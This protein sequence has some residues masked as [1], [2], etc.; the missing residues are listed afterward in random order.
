[1]PYPDERISIKEYHCVMDISGTNLPTVKIMHNTLGDIVWTRIGTGECM[2]TL[3][4][5]LPRNKFNVMIGQMSGN[6]KMVWG[7]Y[8]LNDNQVYL[9]TQTSTG[10][11]S[12][13]AANCTIIIRVYNI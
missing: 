9:R 6:R 13:G 8:Q 7:G 5:K 11:Q 1:M 4:G 2:G 3:T 12:E 10:S